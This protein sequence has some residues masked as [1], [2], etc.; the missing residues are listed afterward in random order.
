MATYDVPQAKDLRPGEKII[1]NV[2]GREFGIFNVE[3]RLRAIRNVCPDQSGPLCLGDV[4]DRIEADVTAGRQIREFVQEKHP[5]VA[6][7][8]HG[9][10]YDLATGECLWNPRYRVRV[11]DLEMAEDGSLK[12]TV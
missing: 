2:G 11:Y 5:V 4:F 8:W 6:C 12:L 10:E 1:V 7:P 9:W 3:G